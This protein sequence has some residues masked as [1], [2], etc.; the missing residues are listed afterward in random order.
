DVEIAAAGQAV[1]AEQLAG[2][3]GQIDIQEL[4]L[5]FHVGGGVGAGY[6]ERAAGNAAIDLRLA[7][8]QRERTAAQIGAEGG[9]AEPGGADGDLRCRQA[10]VQIGA[11]QRVE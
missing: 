5:R 1:D 10:P 7:N 11:R 6:P 3:G 9:A 8:R 2:D 4:E